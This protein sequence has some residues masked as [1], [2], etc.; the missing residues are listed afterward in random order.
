MPE[1]K[2]RPSNITVVISKLIRVKFRN[3]PGNVIDLKFS[4]GS[5]ELY[6]LNRGGGKSKP[7]S[8]G[9]DFTGLF[10]SG[11]PSGA[12]SAGELNLSLSLDLPQGSARESL[13]LRILVCDK[14][15]FNKNT[16][17][18]SFVDDNTLYSLYKSPDEV[19]TKLQE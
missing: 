13:L 14:S 3:S 2:D 18:F 19:I 4:L 10:F 11:E 17:F 15:P 9:R 12:D 8:P 5:T 6:N 1:T 7:F 16:E